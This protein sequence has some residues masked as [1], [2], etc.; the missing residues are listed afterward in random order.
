MSAPLLT[1]RN[2][3]AAGC[4]DPPIID[5]T[6]RGQYVGYFENQ[7]GEQ[8][9]FTRNRRTGTATLRG[10]DMGWNTAVDVTDGTVE[11]LVLGESESLWLQSCLDSSRPKART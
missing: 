2:H 11:Q 7:F 8:W 1:I 6:G 9:I 3:H 4:G 10:G 5:G